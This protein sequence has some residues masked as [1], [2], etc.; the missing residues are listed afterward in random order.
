[1]RA[2]TLLVAILGASVA[3]ASDFDDCLQAEPI[4][5]SDLE[6]AERWKSCGGDPQDYCAD[7]G[8]CLES[9]NHE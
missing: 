1:M 8:P 6:C 5:G 2:F 9:I 3:M 7:G 4:C